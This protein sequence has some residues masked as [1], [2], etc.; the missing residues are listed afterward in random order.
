[1]SL[2]RRSAVGTE[3]RVRPQE[4]ERDEPYGPVAHDQ[5]RR[6]LARRELLDAS[7]HC[8]EGFDEAACVRREA[9]RKELEPPGLG[10]QVL[11]VTPR[12]LEADL[13]AVGE[14]IL[15]DAE[16]A[17]EGALDARPAEVH[18]AAPLVAGDRREA[19]PPPARDH[20]EVRRADAAG[21]RL[22]AHTAGSGSS[23]ISSRPGAVLTMALT[24]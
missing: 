7:H 3:P 5:R 16:P 4:H 2:A 20:L 14:D 1:L 6:Q 22:H 9:F 17:G 13:S 15:A 19:G 8:G 23:R 18:E 11:G 24:D 12:M 21:E 10:E